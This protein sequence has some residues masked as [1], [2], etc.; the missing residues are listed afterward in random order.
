[1]S[2]SASVFGLLV[3]DFDNAP[4]IRLMNRELSERPLSKE[5][6]LNKWLYCCKSAV[7]SLLDLSQQDSMSLSSLATDLHSCESVREMIPIILKLYSLNSSLYVNVNQFLRDFPV[8]L[9]GKFLKEVY[10]VVGY[11]YLLQSSIEQLSL[12]HPLD[13][14]IVYRG[15]RSDGMDHAQLYESVIGQVTVW[16]GFASTSLNLTYVI[17]TFVHDSSGLLFEISLPTGAAAAS[18]QSF[19]AF[20]M[21]SEILIAASSG[22]VVDSVDLISVM[23]ERAHMELTIPRVRLTYFLS[24]YDFDL[25]RRPPRLILS[26]MRE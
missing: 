5:N 26:D 23:N 10:G 2:Q 19:S 3:D 25:D 18:I 15:F 8:D 20:R 12:L 16:R 17:S 14:C 24:W 21:E 22:F 4:I 9:I 1:M 6:V 7:N 11:A 13:A